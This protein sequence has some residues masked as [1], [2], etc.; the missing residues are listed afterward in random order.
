MTRELN[1]FGTSGEKSIFLRM[2][3]N[4]FQGQNYQFAHLFEKY[5][6]KLIVLEPLSTN[7]IVETSSQNFKVKCR[8]SKHCFSC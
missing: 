4:K 8:I 2:T 7:H 3:Q 5:N 1:L 6:G